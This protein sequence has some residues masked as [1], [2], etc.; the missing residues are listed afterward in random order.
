MQVLCLVFKVF[1]SFEL[2]EL[3]IYILDINS[4]SHI[5]FANIFSH[6]LDYVFTELVVSVLCRSFLN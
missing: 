1:V 4:L 6:F 5:K 3:D 2:L